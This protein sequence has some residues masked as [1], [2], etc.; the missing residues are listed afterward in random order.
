MTCTDDEFGGDGPYCAYCRNAA[1]E[2]RASPDTFD[3]ADHLRNCLNRIREE[4]PMAAGG[5]S[6]G[7]DANAEKHT[8]T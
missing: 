4:V 3:I 1:A 5:Q 2:Y 6:D 8:R 7:G